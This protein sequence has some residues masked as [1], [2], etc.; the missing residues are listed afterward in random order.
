MAF[1][2]EHRLNCARLAPVNRDSLER[3]RSAGVRVTPQRRVILE[4]IV[5]HPGVHPSAEEILRESR[6]RL[7]ELSRGTVYNTLNELV[8][9]GLLQT[10]PGAGPLRY[11]S[12]LEREHQHFRCRG[13]GRLFDVRIAGQDE[14]R[15]ELDDEFRVERTRIVLEG[16][17]PDCYRAEHDR[18][19]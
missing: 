7:P 3:L 18:R 11:D 17:C 6:R 8:R 13:C 19:E 16:I 14:L 4:A 1:K 5:E 12:N 15:P 9:I 2:E 10:V